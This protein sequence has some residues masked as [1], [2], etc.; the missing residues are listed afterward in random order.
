[1][2]LGSRY[3]KNC[4]D[5]DAIETANK[6]LGTS[7]DTVKAVYEHLDKIRIVAE[8]GELNRGLQGNVPNV[9]DNGDGSFTI[10]GHN[11][12]VTV[13]NG[14][15][16]KVQPNAWDTGV[17]IEDA[18]GVITNINNGLG[19]RTVYLFTNAA[20]RPATPVG[21]NYVDGAF[22]DLG[23]WNTYPS[24]INNNETTWVSV[25]T[26]NQQVTG[27]W[28]EGDWS[29]PTVFGGR[30]GYTPIK[31]TDYFDG[32][33]GAYI[34]YVYQKMSSEPARPVGGDFTGDPSTEVMPVGW[35]TDPP[36]A[37]G[38]EIVWV[39]VR[40]YKIENGIWV[41][42]IWSL[43]RMFS[44]KK[45]DTP[46][47]GVDFVDGLSGDY[48]SYAYK[49]SASVPLVPADG[50]YDGENEVMPTGWT[51]D[52]STAPTGQ[53][54]WVIHTIYRNTSPG[55]WSR[56]AWSY[57]ARFS[58][59][60]PV[61]GVDYT[62]GIDGSYTSFIFTN[63]E[64]KPI[65]PSGGSWDGTN[66]V[67]P[68]GWEDDPV[69]PTGN[70]KVWM[71]KRKY[72]H[73]GT[74][75]VPQSG[76]S[77]PTNWSGQNGYTPVYGTDYFNGSAGRFTSYIYR[78]AASVPPKPVGGSYNGTTELIPTGWYDDPSTPV[79]TDVIWISKTDYSVDNDGNWIS[80]GWSNPIQFNSTQSAVKFISQIFI[81]SAT[82][83]A[84]PTG[85]S[86][87]GTDETYPTGWDKE[88]VEPNEG[89]FIY[90]S[91]TTYSFDG[92]NWTNTG[93]SIPV[94]FSQGIDTDILAEQIGNIEED[95]EEL[96]E[97]IIW[98]SVQN[99]LTETNAGLNEATVFIAQNAITTETTA[100]VA[101][102]TS[103]QA[104]IDTANGRI[105][106]SV[107]RLDAVEL[108][109]GGT[110]Q[111]ISVLQGDVNDATTGLSATYGLAQQAKLSSDGNA[112][113]ITQINGKV[114][115]A[116]T[117]LT[118]TY[119]IASAAK[120]SSEGNA[121][122]ILK[123]EGD[124]NDAATG[125]AA[126]YSIASAAKLSSDGNVQSITAL[127]NTVGDSS[128]GLVLA[129]E[130]QGNDLTSVKA[131]AFL[132][133]NANGRVSGIHI[134]GSNSESSINF[135]AERIAFVDSS[136]AGKLVWDN[137]ENTLAFSGKLQAATG[138]FS[139][140]L[141]AATG[142]FSGSVDIGTG[143]FKTTIN[144]TGGFSA[145]T[146]DIVRLTGH[147]LVF[148]ASGAGNVGEFRAS[149]DGTAV[150]ATNSSGQV[151]NTIYASG[152]IGVKASG[153]QADFYA[154][155]TGYSPFTG[156]HDG[157]VNKLE[158]LIEQGD[159]VVDTGV[160]N[161]ANISNVI[162][163]MTTSSQ[164]NQRNARGV[165][166]HRSNLLPEDMPAGLDNQPETA[167]LA[168]VFDRI[169]FNALGEG[170]MNV[171]GENGDI[172]AGDLITT[173][174]MTGKGMKQSDQDNLKPYTVAQSRQTV[175]FSSPDEVKQI[176][177]IYKCG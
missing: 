65:T 145:W 85:G 11:G 160:V 13:S 127:E 60:T 23:I 16:P 82:R 161:I 69:A 2:G 55:V 133:V 172:Q 70:E 119:N 64:N 18:D 45:G 164:P 147:N 139:G 113:S 122:S 92:T 170:A 83:P 130:Q 56:Q 123:L 57:P 42:S 158:P 62:D 77:Q 78:M 46:E 76:W 107:T 21:I 106:G 143:H 90:T 121:T 168:L 128:S 141:Q 135:Q 165:L 26:F 109:V 41:G 120:T 125:L 61:R 22:E 72:I 24:D 75:F 5:K 98:N 112:T 47:R 20:Q 44:G 52:P 80:N 54:I 79:G 27:V 129:V 34:S 66:E 174:S 15:S 95:V 93:W 118:A 167:S 144:D 96:L 58:G 6:Y 97:D 10:H 35:V 4:S 175:T 134:N 150:Y 117:G 159:I 9:T 53:D 73:N 30:D 169:S 131:R 89:E 176:A 14:F 38:S 99:Q 7:Y 1:M 111:A 67:I 114:N 63:A 87:D 142:T 74:S 91:F 71:S 40:R 137:T 17:T 126:T 156:S 153:S 132:G 19:T 84:T 33:D 155:S 151:S 140:K 163:S 116:N 32:S 12:D 102:G 173:S 162:C 39:A 103:L 149:G 43:P 136:G 50:S 51:D 94:V 8:L 48:H 29:V 59:K 3:G 138:T 154:A 108:D 177:V 148:T 105:D 36:N 88:P 124:V 37:V 171:C 110:K 104:N 157:L 25:C 68:T 101:Q 146:G 28:T 152:W 31:G 49:N 115:D 81:T 100:R 86:Y 166:I